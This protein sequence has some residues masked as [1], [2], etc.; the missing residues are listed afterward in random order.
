MCLLHMTF[1]YCLL[2]NV[3]VSKYSVLWWYSYLTKTKLL[4]ELWQYLWHLHG[5]KEIPLNSIM[6]LETPNH[7]RVREEGHQC[8]TISVALFSSSGNILHWSM[9]PYINIWHWTP[10]LPISGIENLILSISGIETFILLISF[11]KHLCLYL[12]LK[13]LFG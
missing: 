8:H 13:P 1:V 5:G 10:F 9:L 7:C 3:T 6:S 12:A 11:G 2:M 4:R